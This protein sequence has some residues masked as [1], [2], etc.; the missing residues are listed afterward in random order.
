[1][2]PPALLSLPP[3]ANRAGLLIL[4]GGLLALFVP[5]YIGLANDVWSND[6][7][8]HGPMILGVCLWLLWYDRHRIFEGV[9]RP[10]PVLGFAVLSL[11]LLLVWFGRSQSIY[12][13]ETAGQPLAFAA[14]LL[15]IQGTTALQRAW[16]PLF[17]M[18]FMIPWPEVMVQSITMPLKHAV[19]VVTEWA[20]FHLGYPI[21]RSGVTLSIGPYQLL[22]ADACA[23]MNSLLTLE[24]LGLLYMRLMNYRNVTRNTIL[25]LAIIP[26]SF[27]AN[28]LRV[29]ILV[30]VTYYFGDEVGQGFVHNFSGLVLFSVSLV[31][32]YGID[33]VLNL[34]FDS[35]A[36]EPEAQAES[37]TKSQQV[38]AKGAA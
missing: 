3:E 22:V 37:G 6:A 19:S 28:V 35:S 33:Q 10:A 16:F 8:S 11:G 13:A 21:G 25:A 2:N 38:N 34:F 12:M 9:P 14:A 17:F 4:I 20:L 30:L 5:T 1:M 7:H 27:L 31:S 29:V 24:S 15:L 32:I 18:L 23:G 36:Q 26:T